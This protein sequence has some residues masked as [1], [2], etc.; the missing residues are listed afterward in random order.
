VHGSDRSHRRRHSHPSKRTYGTIHRISNHLLSRSLIG[1]GRPLLCSA[2][3]GPS[4]SSQSSAAG[5][6]FL[7]SRALPGDHQALPYAASRYATVF[8]AVIDLTG[9]SL[10]HVNPAGERW[11]SKENSRVPLR[12]LPSLFIIAAACWPESCAPLSLSG[13]RWG[14]RER[15]VPGRSCG[16]THTG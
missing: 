15:R 3:H 16:T 1:C 14:R 5:G 13:G 9:L 4:C 10:I 6:P 12:R 2:A 7:H 8:P 11:I